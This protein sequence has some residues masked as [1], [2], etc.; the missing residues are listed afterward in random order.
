MTHNEERDDLD[1]ELI[2]EEDADDT[3][4]LLEPDVTHNSLFSTQH[5]EYN[6]VL[7]NDTTVEDITS[8]QSHNTLEDHINHVKENHK[9]SSTGTFWL[10]LMQIVA[11]IQMF[12]RY[13]RM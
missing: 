5:K 4:E 3:R 13:K 2:D 8:S 1:M 10:M 12:S 11:I 7:V 6:D 9:W